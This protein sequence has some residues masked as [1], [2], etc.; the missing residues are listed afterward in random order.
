MKKWLLGRQDKSTKQSYIWYS[1]GGLLNAGQSALLLIVISRTNPEAD[2]GI[3]SIGYAIACLAGTIGLYGM[4]NFQVTDVTHRYS[5]ST[6]LK[7][8]VISCIAMMMLVLYYILKG[9]MRLDYSVDKCAVILLLGLLKLVDAVEDVYHAKY[10][11]VGRLDIAGRC[12]ATRFMVMLLSFSVSLIFTGNLVVSSAISFI[13]SLGYFI[14][15][16]KMTYSEIEDI[17]VEESSSV[18]RLLTEC[19]ALF[20]GTFLALYIAN[21]PKYAIDEIC[22]EIDQANYNYIFMPVYVVNVLNTFI[23]QPVLAKM[24]G[25]F[26]KKDFGQF[27]KLFFRQIFIIV[28]ILMSILLGGYLLGIPVLSILYNTDLSE[29][30]LAF[31]ILLV[32]SGFLATEGYI[33]AIITIMRKQ[34]WLLIGFCLSAVAAMFA[35]NPIVEQYGILGASLLYTGIVFIRMLIF[36]VMFICFWNKQVAKA[37]NK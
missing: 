21:A 37:I 6:Y 3:Y 25:I 27:M 36:I 5:F 29:Y 19:F 17:K 30:K 31:I 11:S 15:V 13:C 2:S 1:L 34:N 28:G 8:R 9:L 23:Y 22:S 14:L 26:E 18:W 7:S 20:A 35:A 12:M 16:T 32:G 10:Q 33:Q 4:R 24:A